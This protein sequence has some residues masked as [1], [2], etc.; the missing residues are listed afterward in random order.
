MEEGE[1]ISLP[2]TVDITYNDGTVEAQSVDW[3]A[4]VDTITTA[5]TYSIA[6]VTSGGHPTVAT[7]VVTARN[8]LQNPG[9]ESTPT[10]MW[11]TTG[12]G[13]TVG[14]TSDPRTGTRSTHFYSDAAY[15]FTVSQTVTGLAPG[16]YVASASLQGDGEGHDDAVT[17]TLD[18]G[19]RSASAPFA[20]DGWQAWSTPTTGPVIVTEEG[21]ATVTISAELSAG[22]WGTIDDVVLRLVPGSG[23]EPG[24]KPEPEPAVEKPSVTLSTGTVARG[25]SVSITAAGFAPH[26]RVEVWLNST[27][28]LL[29]TGRASAG[30]AYATTVMIPAA[31]TPGMHRLELRGASSGSVFSDLT[32]LAR[33]AATGTEPGGA[34]GWGLALILLG[35]ATVAVRRWTMRRRADL[36]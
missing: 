21:T 13:V 25:G 3:D 28:V 12:T 23:G 10:T 2:P 19:D 7:I 30:G 17:I 6:G 36:V 26:E 15:S 18:S 27:P 34:I 35:T 9:F 1:Q 29:A 22:A 5:G 24:P 31:V 16:E 8:L 20:M 11:T 4:T 14:S 32:V 33:L